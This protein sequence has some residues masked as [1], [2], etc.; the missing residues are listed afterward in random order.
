MSV[1]REELTAFADG[2]LSPE[3]A[4]RIEVE[5]AMDAELSRQL[6]AERR[7]R[8]ALK[9]Q[10]DP[11]LDEPVPDALNGLLAQ[12]AAQEVDKGAT[13]APSGE[14]AQVLDFA[15]ARERRKLAEK[16]AAKKARVPMFSN[17]RLGFALAASLVLGLMLGT[18]F[19]REGS[20]IAPSGGGLR[21]T[22]KLA[23]GLDEQLASANPS[24][25]LRILTSFRR[26]GGDFCR[27]FD[28]GGIAG[29]ACK[30]RNGWVLE[31]TMASSKVATGEY[32]QAGSA[33][34]D[35][36]AVA[37][38]MALGDPLDTDQERAAKAAGWLG[39]TK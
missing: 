38:D 37:Q 18:Q 24:G 3:D 11:I 19:H 1:T 30:D 5:I 14:P 31:R 35:L 6:I 23:S 2:E 34:A 22:G 16:Q 13:G 21:A 20:V 33:E 25:N 12:A 26:Q 15:A 8:A 17:P 10:L 28:G 7:L 27:V 39:S 36:M 9:R 4:A 32:R 29:L